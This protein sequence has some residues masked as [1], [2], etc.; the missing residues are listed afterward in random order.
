MTAACRGGQTAVV[1][2]LMRALAP[3]GAAAVALLAL[4]PAAAPDR[5]SEALV[6]LADIV[7]GRDGAVVDRFDVRMRASLSAEGLRAAWASYERA[8]GRYVGHGA[9]QSS[10]L[11]PYTVVQVALTMSGR[12]GEF[13]I[14]FAADGRTAGLYFL[15]SGVPL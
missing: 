7:A 9:P 2:T 11:P 12:G 6:L 1:R 4:P 3:L 13:R 10:T 14:S 8:F 15:R 5:A